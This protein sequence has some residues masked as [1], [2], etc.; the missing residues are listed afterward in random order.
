MPN[1]QYGNHTI[2][3]AVAIQE[4]LKAHYISVSKEE[5]VVLKGKAISSTKAQELVLT[6]A[7]WILD[8]LGVVRSIPNDAIVTGSRMQYLGR[9]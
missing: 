7:R 2:D 6:K 1:I 3:Y 9:K 4:D 5:G 8:K